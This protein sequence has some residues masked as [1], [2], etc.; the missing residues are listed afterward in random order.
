MESLGN[1]GHFGFTTDKNDYQLDRV[2]GQGATAMVMAARFTHPETKITTDCAIK[3]INLDRKSENMNDISKE[4]A[5]ML[6]CR[7]ENIVNYY[8]SFVVQFDLWLVMNLLGGGSVY[9]IIK[10][11][12]NQGGTEN[13]VLEEVEI[14]TVLHE[15]LKGLQYL[16]ANGQIHRDIK[17]GNIL[18]GCDGSVQLGDFGVSAM[19]STAAGDRTAQ[20]KRETFVGTVCWMAPEVMEQAKG[21]DSRADIWSLGIV[22]IEMVTGSAP[23]N[24]YPPMKVILLTLQNNAPNLDTVDPESKDKYKKYSSL[25]RKFIS[26]CLQ[27]EPGKRPSSK[28]LLKEGFMKK[29]KSNSKEF[30]VNR[31]LIT[32]PDLK[33]RGKK[34]RRVKGSSGKF[35]KMD[36]G[37]WEFSD[38]E[39]PE[40]EENL[41]TMRGLRLEEPE[42]TITPQVV[43]EDIET[44]ESFTLTLRIRSQ[45]GELQ[46]VSFPFVVNYDTASAVAQ[47]M[48]QSRIIESEDMIIVASKISDLVH[49]HRANRD[50]LTTVPEAERQCRFKCRTGA[51]AFQEPNPE[52]LKGFAQL[53]IASTTVEE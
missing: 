40:E 42:P 7:H 12:Q 29:A 16:H 21:Y 15:A 5:Y 10:H 13:G 45:T 52:E 17:A 37:N 33:D 8:K 32:V 30:I 19:I 44:H 23:Y 25:L 36:N 24:K 48:M 3:L 50:N 46:D 31:L 18:L 22:A 20:G 11:R 27:K 6:K 9:D 51:S 4:V 39:C 1:G 43:A 47:E 34:I 38:D 53:T 28:E 49:N 26:K 14:A 41:N 35:H 2:I